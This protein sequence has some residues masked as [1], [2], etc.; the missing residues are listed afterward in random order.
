M[1]SDGTCDP[2][3]IL[4]QFNTRSR[5]ISRFQLQAFKSLLDDAC[6]QMDDL[7]FIDHN[8][9]IFYFTIFV[10]S[11]NCEISHRAVPFSS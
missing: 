5:H 10:P 6:I 1:L 4:L 11:E 8:G 2:D 3:N 7:T 9:K